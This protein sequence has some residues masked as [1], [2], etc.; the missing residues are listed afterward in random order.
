MLSYYTHISK[1]II[2]ILYITSSDSLLLILKYHITN[3]RRNINK[4]LF[5]VSYVLIYMLLLTHS[6]LLVKAIYIHIYIIYL[7]LKKLIKSLYSLKP[8]LYRTFSRFFHKLLSA[9]IIN[10][11][12]Y[13]MLISYT[14]IHCTI[15]TTLH[16]FVCV[17]EYIRV[18]M[19]VCVYVCGYVCVCV[20]I[21]YHFEYY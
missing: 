5:S 3:Y 8:R 13:D 1:R 2:H 16:V 6:K 15:P 21:L 17:C 9:I 10:N 12:Q 4:Y 19:Y 14:H 18:P 20:L 7:K 11:W